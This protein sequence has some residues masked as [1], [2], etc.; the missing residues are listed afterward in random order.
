MA[1]EG[2]L[3]GEGVESRGLKAAVAETAGETAEEK[4]LG[5]VG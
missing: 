4:D 1:V 3:A 5:S 2:G